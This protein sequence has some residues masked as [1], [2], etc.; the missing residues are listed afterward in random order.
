MIRLLAIYLLATCGF[1]L[2]GCST[3]VPPLKTEFPTPLIE[4]LPVS[5]GLYYDDDLRNFTY[6]ETVSDGTSWTI[7]LGESN[8]RLFNRLFAAM[9]SKTVEI[10]DIQNSPAG[11]DGIIHPVLEEYAFLTPAELGSRFYAVSIRYRVFLY[12]TDGNELAAWP[13]NAYGQSRA[14]VINAGRLRA[15]PLQQATN[16]AMRDA[17]AG[18]I[19][20]LPAQPEIVAL[21]NPETQTDVAVDESH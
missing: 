7:E 16:L 13:I 10:D 21:T 9:F 11:L 20:T 1:V 5:V 19:I 15:G 8:L 14:G 2:S 3:T 4:N 6:N 18:A 12:D 17:A